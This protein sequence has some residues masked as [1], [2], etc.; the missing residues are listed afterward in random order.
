MSSNNNRDE[1]RNR[2]LAEIYY[3]E[4]G[5]MPKREE[6]NW[7]FQMIEDAEKKKK[8]INKKDEKKVDFEF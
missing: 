1:N 2:I 5:Q 8:L 7:F 6:F 3:D 4:Y